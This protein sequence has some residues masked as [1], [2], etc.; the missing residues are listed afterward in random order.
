[1]QEKTVLIYEFK[2]LAPA[3]QRGVLF[4]HE[5]INLMDCWWNFV[6]DMA[7]WPEFQQNHPN[8]NGIRLTDFCLQK[9]TVELDIDWRHYG[10]TVDSQVMRDQE[11][12]RINAWVL[13]LL[14]REFDWLASDEAVQES[15]EASGW[16]F[17][18]DG[19]PFKEIYTRPVDQWQPNIGIDPEVLT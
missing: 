9:N 10:D 4:Q 8:V 2:E 6:N 12:S 1:M 19:T 13:E 18:R 7:S 17:F 3:I 16:R 15:I 5:D 14:R 11:R